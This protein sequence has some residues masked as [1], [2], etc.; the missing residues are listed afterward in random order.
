MSAIG[1][2]IQF[3]IALEGIGESNVDQQLQSLGG[4]QDVETRAI[5]H[6]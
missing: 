3:R 6:R 4:A 1:S 5:S 2:S